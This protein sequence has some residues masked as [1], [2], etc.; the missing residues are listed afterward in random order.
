MFL[1]G[2]QACSSSFSCRVPTKLFPNSLSLVY[3]GWIRWYMYDDQL[4]DV[5]V[6]QVML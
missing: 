3:S 4:Q 6:V 5:Q 1:F 2:T